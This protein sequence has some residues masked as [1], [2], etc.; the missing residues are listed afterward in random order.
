MH[1]SFS[2]ND[3]AAYVHVVYQIWNRSIGESIYIYLN[4]L[5]FPSSLLCSFFFIFFDWKPWGDE[6]SVIFQNVRLRVRFQKFGTRGCVVI[7]WLT[8]SS[9]E[10]R[11]WRRLLCRHYSKQTKYSRI[12]G[13]VRKSQKN[14]RAKD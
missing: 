14:Q 10:T 5:I 3:I 13:K 4:W 9:S 1:H 11:R 7:D 2:R 6:K 8:F 12:S